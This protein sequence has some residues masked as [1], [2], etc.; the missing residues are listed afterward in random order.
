MF[1]QY[2]ENAFEKE[3]RE[4]AGKSR[5]DDA[6]LTVCFTVFSSDWEETM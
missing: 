1:F 5:R 4:F 6:L 2:A 3:T